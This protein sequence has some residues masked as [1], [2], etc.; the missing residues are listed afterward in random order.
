M[1][2]IVFYRG[3]S[4]SSLH[5]KPQNSKLANP[6]FVIRNATNKLIPYIVLFILVFLLIVI[7]ITVACCY[8]GKYCMKIRK[9]RKAK[10]KEGVDKEAVKNE[11]EI[12]TV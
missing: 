12:V 4:S 3:K 5:Y 1:C 8:G 7:L 9:E 2:C 6:I 10:K 11:L